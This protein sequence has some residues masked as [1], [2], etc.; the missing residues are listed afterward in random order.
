MDNWEYIQ[1][2]GGKKFHVPNSETAYSG[3]GDGAA[4]STRGGI[5]AAR[6]IWAGSS[7]NAN[8]NLNVNGRTRLATP[9]VIDG[10]TAPTGSYDEGI[11]LIA[12]S[13]GWCPILLGAPD[14][15]VGPPN[16]WGIYRTNT[17]RFAIGQNNDSSGLQGLQITTAN[18]F[19]L[20]GV[21]DS[22]KL[23]VNGA[24]RATNFIPTS[25]S[26]VKS[27]IAEIDTTAITA[28][29]K[30]ELKQYVKNG[31]REFGVIAQQVL[32][33]L[34]DAVYIPQNAGDMM[35]VNY[36]SILAAKC[37]QYEEDIA[38]LRCEVERLKE[39]V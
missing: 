28:I 26:R 17:G 19:G 22:Y 37:A 20:G 36:N 38:E 1:V 9:L 27:G 11:R 2:F 14:T 12:S 10:R 21:D 18:N 33:Y 6:S 8:G 31:K 15:N 13:S 7:L 39:L 29:R 5:S 16:G 4:I 3:S 23:Y 35:G 34:P 25:D 32:P 30:V 24:V